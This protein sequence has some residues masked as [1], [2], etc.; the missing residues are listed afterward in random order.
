MTLKSSTFT[1]KC[2]C[3]SWLNQ[4]I[5]PRTIINQARKWAFFSTKDLKTHY[6]KWIMVIFQHPYHNWGYSSKQTPIPAQIIWPK[7]HWHSQKSVRVKGGAILDYVY[8]YGNWPITGYKAWFFEVWGVFIFYIFRMS[9][10]PES[11][12]KDR[13]LHLSAVLQWF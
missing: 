10:S 6:L 8:L 3:N 13:N 11:Q 2:L 12:L 5:P 7:L 1:W 9:I 4:N